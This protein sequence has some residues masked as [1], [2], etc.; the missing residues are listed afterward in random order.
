MLYF[1]YGSNLNKWQMA[2]RC[3]R[4]VSLGRLKLPDWRLVFR[5]VADLIPD[6]GA[7]CWGGVWRITPECERALDYYEGV[8]SGLYRK[9]T[10]PIEPL[11]DGTNEMLVY[12]MNSD[13]VFPPSESYLASIVKGYR[14]F[15][16]PKSARAALNRAVAES[17]DDKAPSHMERQ[18]HRRNGR[19]RLA[20]RPKVVPMPAPRAEVPR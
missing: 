13:G 8:A 10:I 14:D 5:G 20:E 3:P 16:L 2:R 7:F 9:E 15:R 4:A 12:V 1:A 17:W 6:E 11:A 19:P 18:R